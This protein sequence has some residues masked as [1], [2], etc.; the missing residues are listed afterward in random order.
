MDFVILGEITDIETIAR[1]RGVREAARLRRV[2]GGMRWRKR[3][4]IARIRLSS[5]RLRLAELH[6]YEAHG[7]GRREFKRKR[8]LD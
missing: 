2:Y 6:W 7:V 1:A 3:K 5:G 4:G 8:Y